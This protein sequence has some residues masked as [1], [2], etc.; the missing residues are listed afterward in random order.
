[1]VNFRLPM[2]DVDLPS[3]GEARALLAGHDPAEDLVL[4]MGEVRF[5]DSTGIGALID[6][7][8]R[9]KAAG[10]RFAVT[11][12]QPQVRHVFDVLGVLSLL[13]GVGP[14]AR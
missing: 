4:D 3:A 11:D 12:L 14:T 8:H 10:S 7:Y 1:V 9:H 2:T 5:C 6:A 13:E